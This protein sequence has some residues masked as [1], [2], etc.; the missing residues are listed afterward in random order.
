MSEQ[1]ITDE[2]TS[3]GVSAVKRFTMKSRDGDIIPSNTYM[4]TFALSTL[5]KSVKAGYLNIGVEVYVPNPPRCFKCQKFGHGSKSCN[6]SVVCQ[7]CGDGHDSTGCTAD[8]K[9]SNC[10]GKH[11]ASSKLCPVWQKQSKIIRLKHE[12]NISFFEAKK[13]IDSQAPSTPLT[14]TYSAAAISTP[15]TPPTVS[16]SIQT[17][18]TWVTSDSPISITSVITSNTSS[19]QTVSQSELLIA[20]S[21]NVVPTTEKPE[22]T[23]EPSTIESGVVTL[24]RKERKKLNKKQ[25]NRNSSSSEIVIHNS[26][27]ALDMDVTPSSQSSSRSPSSSRLRERSP[28]EP[29]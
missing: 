22:A 8:I 12:Q 6:H 25:T 23:V 27:D 21:D 19:T 26:F 29:P 2:L 24:T 7:R 4:L 17:E 18:M 20:Y 5:P 3:Q 10:N 11:L 28:I 16:I 13:V 15:P 9:C 14:R 1:E